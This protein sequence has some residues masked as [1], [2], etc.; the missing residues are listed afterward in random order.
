MKNKNNELKKKYDIDYIFS[1]TEYGQIEQNTKLTREDL[2]DYLD[3]PESELAEM[4]RCLEDG[5]SVHFTKEITFEP[6]IIIK[7]D[8]LEVAENYRK[9]ELGMPKI[10]KIDL[11]YW[12]WDCW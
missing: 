9:G 11:K 3:D 4:Q 5:N 12:E 2:I 8:P 1:N 10:A 7:S 6:L